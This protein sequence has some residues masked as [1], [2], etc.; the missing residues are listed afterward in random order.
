MGLRSVGEGLRSS[1]NVHWA[2][3]SVVLLLVLLNL[4]TPALLSGEGATFL[5]EGNLSVT[6]S[7]NGTLSF[8]VGSYGN[9]AYSSLDVGINTSAPARVAAGNATGLRWDLWHNSSEVLAA[10]FNVSDD[11]PFAVNVTALYISSTGGSGGNTETMTYGTF[12]FVPSTSGG[13]W[14][15]TVYP[16]YPL[17]GPNPLPGG[18]GP[19]TWHASD[20]PQT[21]VLAQGPP[22]ALS[23]VSAERTPG[24]TSLPRWGEGG[25]P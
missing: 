10:V 17:S 4:I 14:T 9:V 18:A 19:F 11:V 23:S 15:L 16:L 1:S 3:G 13:S 20:L 21:L 12:A 2:L 22:V 5:S 24:S 6:L 7:T 8:A 25:R